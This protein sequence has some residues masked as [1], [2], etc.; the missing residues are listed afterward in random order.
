[1]RIPL[2]QVTGPE[3]LLVAILI[4]M[5]AAVCWWRKRNRR[6]TS[7]ALAP[8]PPA[9]TIDPYELAY[10]RAGDKELT[11]VL[12]LK[13]IETEYLRVVSP[14][15]SFWR[16]TPKKRVEHNPDHPPVA[17]LAP[18]E[19][20]AFEYF[21]F[22]RTATDVFRPDKTLR[23]VDLP[24][25]LRSHTVKY[26]QRLRAERLLTS[27]ESR[28]AARRNI[29]VGIAIIVAIGVARSFNGI[30][31]GWPVGFLMLMAIAGIAA[32]AMIGRTGRLSSRGK[33]YL[34]ATQDA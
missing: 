3:F 26:E 22:S 20:E 8:L 30:R 19:L 31:W 7:A 2:T 29:F 17:N 11:R 21:D 33:D 13:L 6:D 16:G 5:V 24:T 32:I 25:A 34:K 27:D 18:I 14:P 15:W 23:Q 1:M 12:I 28:D 9:K 10:F 4:T